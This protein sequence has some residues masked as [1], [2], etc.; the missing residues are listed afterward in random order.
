MFLIAR[1]GKKCLTLQ[2]YAL[3]YA[4]VLF[5]FYECFVNV[6]TFKIF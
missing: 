5:S 2:F 4:I 1:I 6:F 3:N